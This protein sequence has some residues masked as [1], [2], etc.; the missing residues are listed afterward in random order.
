VNRRAPVTTADLITLSGY[1]AGLWWSVGGP[2]W[3]ALAS[4]LADEVDGPVAKAMGDAGQQAEDIDWGADVA[5]VPLAL[6]RLGREIGQQT[7]AVA[8]A[9]IVLAVQARLRAG[10]WTPPV[11]SARAAIM[12]ATI[13]IEEYQKRHPSARPKALRANPATARRALRL[14]A[15][16]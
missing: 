2:T 3:A 13:A 10:G 14:K 16:S 7:A 15:R 4:I 1:A 5:L 11:G 9:P 6:L 12:L 8:C